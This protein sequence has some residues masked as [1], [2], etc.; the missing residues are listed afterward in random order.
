MRYQYQMGG[1]YAE[2]IE[3]IIEGAK[4]V[5]DKNKEK[6]KQETAAKIEKQDKGKPGVVDSVLAPI[7][8]A[9]RQQAKTDI[10]KWALIF[11]GIYL[12]TKGR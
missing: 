10:T 11:I 4:G 1:A 8:D 12:L 5:Y 9:A 7:K 6:K 3:G 2:L